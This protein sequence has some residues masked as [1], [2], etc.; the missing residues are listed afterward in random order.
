M[1]D[2]K[3]TSKKISSTV[4]A[5]RKKKKISQENLWFL[6]GVS[7]GSI[8]RFENSGEISLVSLIKILDVLGLEIKIQ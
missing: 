3:I 7:L 4:R 2:P 6:S 5:F 8:K 1:K